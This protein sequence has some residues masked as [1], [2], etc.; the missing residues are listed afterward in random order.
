MIWSFLRE[1]CALFPVKRNRLPVECSGF[2]RIFVLPER[3]VNASRI[4][5]NE[6]VYFLEQLFRN[7]Q[8]FPFSEHMIIKC[9]LIL[10]I[11]LF[12]LPLSLFLL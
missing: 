7:S 11:S 1:N 12:F 6:R 9:R 4:A 10:M 5:D 2:H 8:V 3:F